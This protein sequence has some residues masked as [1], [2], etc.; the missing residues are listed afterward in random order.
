[1][2]REGYQELI[3]YVANQTGRSNNMTWKVLK[4]YSEVLKESIRY[5]NTVN[6]EGL[7]KIEY[8]VGS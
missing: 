1:M 2:I 6:I 8:K 3:D 7:V 5:G 4:E